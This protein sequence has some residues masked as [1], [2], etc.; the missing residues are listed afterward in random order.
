M[1]HFQIEMVACIQDCFFINCCS[2]I[3]MYRLPY[4]FSKYNPIWKKNNKKQT[5]PTLQQNARS[6]LNSIKKYVGKPTNSSRDQYFKHN[7]L[8]RNTFP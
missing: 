6:V 3:D 8:S 2:T 5:Y 4:I 7:Q 1:F